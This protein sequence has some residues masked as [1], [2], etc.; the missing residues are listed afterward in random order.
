MYTVSMHADISDET[1]ESVIE[2]AGYSLTGWAKSAVWDD[3][4]HTYTVT[5]MDDEFT[6]EPEP[7]V[8]L[9]YDALADAMTRILSEDLIARRVRRYIFDAVTENDGA[10][11]DADA[12]DAIVQIAM[13]GRL[14]YG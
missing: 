4:K 8:V 12:G 6:G 1:I 3:E 5:P 10:E 9:T 13:F 14:V 7:T 2:M 11:I